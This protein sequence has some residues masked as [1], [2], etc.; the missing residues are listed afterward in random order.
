MTA[1]QRAA[2]RQAGRD[3][4]SVKARAER[5][6]PSMMDA[7]WRNNWRKESRSFVAFVRSI[8]PTVPTWAVRDGRGEGYRAHPTYMVCDY[9]RRRL[10]CVDVEKGGR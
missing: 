1:K 5:L 8:D 4:A 7:F 3:L 2:I 9:M 6:G 10:E